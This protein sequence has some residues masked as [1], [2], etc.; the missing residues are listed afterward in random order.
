MQK[1]TVINLSNFKN[2]FSFFKSNWCLLILTFSLLFGLIFGIFTFNEDNSFS[3]TLLGFTESFISNRF[4]EN[5]IKIFTSSFF[6]SFAFILG[7]FIFGTSVTGVTLV[8]ILVAFRGILLGTLIGNIYFEYSLTGIAFN[9]LIII[10]P[11]VITIIFMLISA[12]DAMRFSLLVI[13]ITLPETATKNLSIKFKSY[14]QR[15]ILL[16]LPI[17]FAALLD[18]W[19]STKLISFLNL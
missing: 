1:G 8:P 19:L 10:P 9:A 11:A 18:A 16:I 15:F 7:I 4:S 12:R 14:C 5:Y 2:I 13:G 6:L 3:K 17:I